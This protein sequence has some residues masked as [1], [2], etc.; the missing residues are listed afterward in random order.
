MLKHIS[1]TP[2]IEFFL[3][4]TGIKSLTQSQPRTVDAEYIPKEERNIMHD[5]QAKSSQGVFSPAALFSMSN[6]ADPDHIGARL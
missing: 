1:V 4:N 6:S 2:L 3:S 5:Q